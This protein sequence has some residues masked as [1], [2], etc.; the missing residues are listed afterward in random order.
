MNKPQ[1]KNK[2]SAVFLIMVF[3]AVVIL[4]LIASMHNENVRK[5]KI[6]LNSG[7]I[8]L[9]T[10]NNILAA[11]SNDNKLYVWNWADLSKKYREYAVESGEAVFASPDTI[12]SVKQTNPDRLAVSGFDAN[13]ESKKIPL[14]LM[15]NTAHLNANPDGSK[16]ILLLER[17]GKDS[18]ERIMYDLLEVLPD[19]GQMQLITAIVSEKSRLEHFSVSDDGR[20]IV[21]TGE[22]NEHGWLFVAD[23][24]EKKIV[25]Q[26]ELPDFRKLYKGVFSKDGEI[27]YLR[28]S[29][30]MLTLVKT[31]SGE[32]VDH[33]MPAKES[34]YTYR[35]QQIQTVVTS[36]DGGL[37]A[38]IVGG[39]IFVWDTKTREK[40]DITGVSHKVISSIAFS[41]DAKYLA[42]SDMRQG[43]DIK[44][45]RVPHH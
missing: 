41:P 39:S 20:Y 10:H 6:P 13:S 15:A 1:Q 3:A 35:T 11:I 26:K 43:S 23:T 2:T 22:K 16:I 37:V 12:M 17:S 34:T 7:I 8:S 32:I 42:T 5:I 19:R 33:W 31:S 25:W 36:N 28:G 24:E 30:S 18:G 4:M 40:Y 38:A 27:I 44:I 9:L 45:V 21:G 29:D 14:L